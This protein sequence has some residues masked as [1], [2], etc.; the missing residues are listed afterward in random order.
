MGLVEV[1]DITDIADILLQIV[2]DYGELRWKTVD[3]NGRCHRVCPVTL[4]V[5]LQ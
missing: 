5:N 3:Y 4:R 1:M 2:T